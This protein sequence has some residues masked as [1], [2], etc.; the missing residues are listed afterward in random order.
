MKEASH[1]RESICSDFPTQCFYVSKKGSGHG[2][3]WTLAGT[4]RPSPDV[5]G[6]QNASSEASVCGVGATS[7]HSL[8]CVGFIRPSYIHLVC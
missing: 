1:H 3:A 2:A 8:S 5:T 7:S 6:A 4:Y